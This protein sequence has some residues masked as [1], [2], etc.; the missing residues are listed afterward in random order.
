[1]KDKVLGRWWLGGVVLVGMLARL[2]MAFSLPTWMDE[3][4]TIRIVSYSFKNLFSG[5]ID[6]G[7]PPGYFLLLKVWTIIGENILW[8]RLSS[9]VFYLINCRFL[10]L[11]G[12]NNRDK[13]YSRV[14]VISYVLS[15]YFLTFDWQIRMYTGLLTMILLSLW[16]LGAK[17]ERKK[18]VWLLTIVGSLG[19]FFDYGYLWYF[20]PLT[21][22]LLL[23]RKA[24]SQQLIAVGGSWLLFGTIWFKVF[25]SNFREGLKQI[26]WLG[27]YG[28]DK[29]EFFLPFFIGAA[30]RKSILLFLFLF[31][32]LGMGILLWLMDKN[33]RVIEKIVLMGALVSLVVSYY[34]SVKFTPLLH[35]RSLQIVGLAVLLLQSRGLVWIIRKKYY[36]L[37][38]LIILGLVINWGLAISTHFTNLGRM[39][40]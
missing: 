14:L 36:W 28:F 39:I 9:V 33:K 3:D 4:T 31:Y 34:V 22:Y 6:L 40:A 20:I 25:I 15:G 7:H 10:Y 12:K 11:I 38:G 2:Y 27:E 1:M 19:L 21:G 8:L 13:F 5:E 23:K 26:E 16:L 18:K 30:H 17:I 35:V 32:L 37:A 29:I 24:Y